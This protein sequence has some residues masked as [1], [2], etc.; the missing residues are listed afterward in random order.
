M[1]EYTRQRRDR[2]HPR[3]RARAVRG[4]SRR[5]LAQRSIASAPI[6]P[7]SST[8]LTEAG[9]LAALI[10]EEYGGSGLTDASA[11][12]ILEEVQAAGCNGAACHAQM[13][14]MGTVLRHGNAAQKQ[15]YLPKIASG[16]LRLQA[17]G[18]TEPTWHRYAGAAHHRGA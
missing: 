11:I 1:T 9:F 12:A 18:V 8:A 10:P 16:E 3:G 17:F 14:M 6:R 4:L 15:R 5:V 13:Y 2:R 7:S